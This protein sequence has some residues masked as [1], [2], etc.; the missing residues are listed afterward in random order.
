LAANALVVTGFFIHSRAGAAK[1]DPSCLPK[2]R[3]DRMAV[4]LHHV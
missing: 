4:S 3:P 1:Y 2:I